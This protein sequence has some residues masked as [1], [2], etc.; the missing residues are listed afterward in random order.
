MIKVL[1]SLL[2][3]KKRLAHKDMP[4]YTGTL[5]SLQ[6]HNHPYPVSYY[7][8]QANSLVS[9]IKMVLINLPLFVVCVGICDRQRGHEQNYTN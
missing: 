2:S 9:L 7:P 1:L 4:T 6:K 5:T 8:S 3:G